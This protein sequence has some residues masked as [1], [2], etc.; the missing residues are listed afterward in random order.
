MLR[1][2]FAWAIFDCAGTHGRTLGPA[3]LGVSPFDQVG[4]RRT[5]PSTLAIEA[6]SLTN[7]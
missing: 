7:G 2:P 6:H 3:A 5:K 4:S 1:L